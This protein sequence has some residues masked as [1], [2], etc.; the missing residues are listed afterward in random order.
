MALVRI[1]LMIAAVWMAQPAAGPAPTCQEWHEC[2]RLALDAYARGEYEQFHD[3]AWRTMQT[4]P[5]RNAELMF[6]LARAQSLSGRTH[7]ALIMLGRLAEM[8]FTGDAAT[9]S[10]FRAVR[11]LRQWAEL[12]ATFNAVTPPP[13]L[14]APALP[15]PKLPA[16][17]PSAPAAAVPPTASDAPRVPGIVPGPAALAYDRASARFV[18]VDPGL[19]KLVVIDERLS[20]V[21]DLVTSDSAGFYD[22]TGL[23]IDP[24]RGDLWVVSAEPASPTPDHRPA[25]ALHR[26]QLISGRPLQRIPCPVDL[27]P[28]RFQDVGVTREGTVMV[29]DTVGNRLLRWRP[30]NHTFTPVVTLHVA[31]ATSLAPAGN[32]SV[33]I[34]HQSGIARVDTASGVVTS[35]T[36][37]GDLQLAGLERIRWA[38]D[39]LVGVQRL[40]DGSQRAVR[41]RIVAGR[42]A[43]IETNVIEG[44]G[45]ASTDTVLATASGDEFYV[46]IHSRGRSLGD[47][48][49]RR[50]VLR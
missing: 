23:E 34:A 24:I 5:A 20:H 39:S 11:E 16:P 7:D 1:L 42:A 33:Y 17:T 10:D 13:A 41:I 14:P 27:Q 46:L 30:T 35:L 9:N 43:G 19:R 38:R 36:G 21:V 18:V 31:A 50:G 6:L 49:V 44:G 40:S 25:S 3:L 2:Q 8:G 48:V 47:V 4:G 45:I 37:S 32:R 12:S 29:L 22:I 26:L 28:C 15:A